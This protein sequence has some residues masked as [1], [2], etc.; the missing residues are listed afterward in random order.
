VL[1][2]RFPANFLSSVHL[3]AYVAE[4]EGP[5]DAASQVR[6]VEA[7]LA[8][9]Q[10]LYG[11]RRY[12]EAVTAFK[13]VQSRLYTLINP[14]HCWWGHALGDRVVLPVG[15]QVERAMAEASLR[16]AESIQPIVTPPRPAVSVRGVPVPEHLARLSNLGF[17]RG[18]A[19]P[20]DLE[21]AATIGLEHLAQGRVAQAVEVLSAALDTVGQPQTQEENANAGTI[22]LDLAAAQLAAGRAEDASQLSGLAATFFEAAG[23]E[24][25]QAQARHNEAV[26]LQRMGNV[27]QAAAAAEKA[28]LAF[29]A[30]AS[31]WGTPVAGPEPTPPDAGGG[32][33]GAGGAGG[34]GIGGGGLGGVVVGPVSGPFVGPLVTR[35][36]GPIGP[37]GPIL[38]DATA[39]DETLL[40]ARPFGTVAVSHAALAA[41]TSA[42]APAPAISPSVNLSTLAFISA[43]DPSRV[44]VRWPGAG[45]GWGGVALPN[46]A[47][48]ERQDRTWAL[49]VPVAEQVATI[50]WTNGTRPSVDVLLDSVY[51]QRRVAT[52]ID[53]L[54]VRPGGIAEWTAHLT[55]L[56]S[57]VTPQALGDCYQQ[58]GNFERAETMYLQAASYSFLN[59]V[60]EAPALWVRLARN[61][62]QWGD[63]LFR[64]GQLDE[65]RQVY[66]RLVSDQ[67]GVPAGSPL[68]DLAVFAGP[69]A[70]AQRVL[71]A[72]DDPAAAAVN[73]AV[74]LPIVGVWGRW[75]YLLAGLDYYGTSYTPVFT[76]EY[77]QQVA[78]AF[79]QQASHAEQEYINFQ[80]HAEAEAASRRDLQGAVALANAETAGR[81]QQL[82]AS[83]AET[84]AMLASTQLAQM[85]AEHAAEDRDR[86]QEL[87]YDQAKF[88]SVAAAHGA[89]EDWHG[90]EIRQ[91]ARDMES[92]SWE[93]NAGKLAAAATYLAGMK[94]YEYQL[95]RLDDVARE[96]EAT[97]PIAR[98]QLDAAHQREAA[99]RLAVQAAQLRADLT[100]DALAAF[101]N[102]VFTPELWSRMAE[103]MRELARG[104]LEWAISAAKLAER[105]YNFETGSDL[106]V[107]KSDYPGSQ[108][109]GLLGAEHLTRDID[110]FTYHYIAHTRTKETNVKD[111]ISLAAEYPLAFA[112][113]QRTGRITFETTLRDLDLRH[114]GLHGQRIQNV[115]VEVIGL[116]PP[117]GVKG[118]LRGG[119]I[120]RY[121][122]A[123]GGERTR[124]HTTDTMA[125]SE[126]TVRNDAFVYRT[127]PRRHGL[128]EGHGVGCS[129][130]LDMPRRS[131]NLDYR[132]ITDVRL[133]LYYN[134]QFDES[135][136]E[137]VLTR[138]AAVGELVHARDLLLRYDFPEAWYTF[139]DSGEM[140]FDLTDRYLPRNETGF[141]TDK[142]SLRLL[143]AEGTSPAGV[144]VTLALPGRAPVRAT[145]DANGDVRP[146]P[147]SDLLGAMGGPLL[148]RWTLAVEPEPGSPLLD[149]AGRLDGDLIEQV[150]LVCQYQFDWPA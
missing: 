46:P 106:S 55:H 124:L 47:E 100:E 114:P 137:A 62:Q 74:A 26:A 64:Q 24:V 4:G 132:F 68:Y 111:V 75:L 78:R 56:Y 34:G 13:A 136:R 130:E 135:L 18:P 97:V 3:S 60:L 141:R 119:G 52:T 104:Y 11:Q 94:S 140:T 65:A 92:G 84:A 10:A 102:E 82:R 72:L 126:Y 87:G 69:A 21:D 76:F 108:T 48:A 15:P 79:A 23:D 129:W 120:S 95:A 101:E 121:R 128:F 139:L 43:K 99:A 71:D 70:D 144:P 31:A 134:A 67:G 51:A 30:V 73:P 142:V 148:G 59:T 143:L 96:M 42:I 80:V 109:G 122:T 37:I 90:N 54:V 98:A 8:Q 83:Q 145:T 113:L 88:Q 45:E 127:D 93:G 49:N 112:E 29:R 85:R 91:L 81:V 115:E 146:D 147:G 7:Q 66:G 41:A 39:G 6:A 36:I 27:E 149:Q 61:V 138:P 110:S 20:S 2:L 150:S 1:T 118:T 5:S 17:S 123:D 44:A 57:F 58:L 50:E 86:Y 105:A 12:Q 28:D 25:G 131:N 116:M 19:V 53:D 32:G 103:A 14:R 89:G 77:L 125:L 38:R 117:E 107:I 35:P 33:G 63:H 22:A 133:V 40:R 9:A 16:L